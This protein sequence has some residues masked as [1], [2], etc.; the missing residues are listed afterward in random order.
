[1]YGLFLAMVVYKIMDGRGFV[2]CIVDCANM[3]GMILF[4]LAAGATFSWVLTIAYLPQRL[5]DILL[6]ANASEAVFMVA[7][8]VL[9][10][11][12]GSILEGLP[13]LLIL[14]PLLM[15]IAEQIGINS[16]H[17]AIVMLIAMG[18]GV[19]IPP[20]GVGFYIAA[21]VFGTK[22]EGTARAM[23]PYF[24]MLCAGLLF[25]AFLPWVTLS[26]P[27]AFNLGR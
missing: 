20:I 22:V 8:I 27:Q 26:L 16:L 21:A 2:R 19:F 23:L 17:Y 7:S 10:I 25:V 6:T 1:V 3:A 15:P 12:T 24:L 18:I 4:I 11:L 5:V 9:L 13:A 14:G